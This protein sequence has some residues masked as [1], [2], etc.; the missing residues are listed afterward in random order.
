MVCVIFTGI[1]CHFHNLVKGI[2]DLNICCKSQ[3]ALGH[4][5]AR[6]RVKFNVNRIDNM[7]IQSISL[8][9][10]LDKDINTFAMRVR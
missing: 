1:R 2:K 5:Y 8:I 7:V 4:H 9:D 10:Q 3:L 6:A